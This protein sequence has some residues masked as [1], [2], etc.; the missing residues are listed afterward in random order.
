MASGTRKLLK[1]LFFIFILFYL[2]IYLFI[3]L[4]IYLFIYLFIEFLSK[5]NMQGESGRYFKTHV[6]EKDY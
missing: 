2:F 5:S 1:F 3:Y 6:Q 4:S